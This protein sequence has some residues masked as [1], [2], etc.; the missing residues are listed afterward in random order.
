MIKVISTEKGKRDME[1]LQSQCVR[2]K[3]KRKKE[4]IECLIERKHA[5]TYKHARQLQ[6]FYQNQM[7]NELLIK[8]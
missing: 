5:Q 3:N 6:N 7:E 8:Y 4:K 1:S 2:R